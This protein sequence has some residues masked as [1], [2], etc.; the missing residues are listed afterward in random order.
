M[1][2]DM[3]LI[4]GLCLQA[5]CTVFAHVA[6]MKLV[7]CTGDIS[8]EIFIIHISEECVVC[9]MNGQYKQLNNFQPCVGICALCTHYFGNSHKLILRR[10]TQCV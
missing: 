2:N 5:V 9:R 6:N 1:E 3:H 8:S 7:S 4:G 10:Y